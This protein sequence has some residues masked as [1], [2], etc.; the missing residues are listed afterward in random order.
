MIAQEDDLPC[1]ERLVNGDAKALEE[2]YDRYAPLVFSVIRNILRHEED[3]EEALQDTWLQLWRRPQS[4]DPRRGS[5]AAWLIT[6]G[7]SR[8]LDLYRHRGSRQRTEEKQAIENPVPAAEPSLS[9][10]E[11]ELR[12]Q[13]TAVWKNLEPQHRQVLELA[14]WEGLSQSEI[15]E[16]IGSPLGTVKSWMRQGMHRLRESFQKGEWR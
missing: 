14:F 16:R 13:M 2:L 5:L 8:A 3:A 9:A 6:V 11:R 10:E 4:Y 12:E 15:A 1:M 7:R